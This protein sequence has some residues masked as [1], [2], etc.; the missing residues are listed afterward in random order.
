MTA[1]F[2]I[3]VDDLAAAR[4]FYAR[5]LG[6]KEAQSTDTSADFDFFGHPLSLRRGSPATSTDSVAEPDPAPRFAAVLPL[7][8]WWILAERL[9]AEELDFILP[10][11]ASY[12]EAGEQWTMFFRDPS[13]NP[14]EIKGLADLGVTLER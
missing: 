2:A 1:H 10:P 8:D 13:G 7:E 3:D 6:C 12:G 5:T 9:E 4:A 11:Q 14:I